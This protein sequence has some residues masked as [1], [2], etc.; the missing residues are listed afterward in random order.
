MM[1]QLATAPAAPVAATT[2]VAPRYLLVSP[3]RDEAQFCRRTLESVVAQTLRPSLWVIVDD[4][5]TDATPAILAEYA[6]RH[7]W[8]R[9][10]RRPDRGRRSVGP[11]VVD[12]FAAGYDAVD[13]RDFEFVCK[14]D[15]D[16]ELPPAYFATLLARMQQQPRIG[17]CSGKPYYPGRHGELVS[18]AIGDE[19]SAGMTKLYRR[20][21]FEAIGGFVHEVMWDG[22]DCHRCRMLGWIA[23]SWDEPALRFVHLRAMGSSDHGVWTGRK[24]HG[25][26]QWF[27]GTGP[28]Y[29]LVSAAYRAA[30][31]PFVIGGLGMLAGY[32]SSM[33]AARPR[34]ADA[35]FRRHLRRY[36][37]AC[38]LLGKRRA[39]ER[40]HRQIRSSSHGADRDRE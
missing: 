14:L 5:S 38:L 32:L 26:G 35:A 33:F 23:C 19:M 18:E 39:T 34:Y 40:L 30:H 24:R 37:L 25:R 17:T 28:L 15:L 1:S 2:G 10:L 29:M 22:I 21:C 13:A 9:V 8:I 16:L 4:G 31:R 7:P 12:A 11:G 36:Q 20:Q 3:C 27:M 6:Q